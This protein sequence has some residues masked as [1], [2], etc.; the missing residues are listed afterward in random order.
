MRGRLGLQAA[1]HFLT[2]SQVRVV[3]SVPKVFAIS[4]MNTGLL[5]L[6]R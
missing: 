4:T 1:A 6:G 3:T 5:S 2:V